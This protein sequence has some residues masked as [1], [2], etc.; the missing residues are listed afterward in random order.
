ML[1][2]N[3]LALRLNSIKPSP[4][5]AITALANSLKEQGKDIVGFGAGEPD[6]DTPVHI[7]EACKLAL[8]NGFTKYTAV[9]GVLSLREAICKKFQT[10]NNL[11]YT[12]NQIIVGTGGKQ[13]L[14]NLFMSV[15]NKGDEVIFSAPYWVSYYDMTLLAEGV[16]KV[17]QTTYEDKFKISPSALENAITEKT[18]I[19]LMNSPSNPTGCIYTFEEL[20]ALAK[21]LEK[22]PHVLIVTDDIY[23]KLIFDNCKFYNLAMISNELAER[24][25]VVNGLSKA[26]AMTG[27]RL[28]YAASKITSIIKAMETMQGQSTSNATSFAQK[29]AEAALLGPLDFLQNMNKAFT[30]RRNYVVQK[31]N[32]YKGISTLV[33]EGAFYVFPSIKNFVEFPKF[34]DYQKSINEISASTAFSKLLLEKYLVAVVPGSAFGYENAFRISYA[35]SMEQIKKGMERIE[36]CVT[37]IIS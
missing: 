21:V 6:F 36:Q 16:P 14:Y 33:P 2:I 25:V 3:F 34:K 4:T 35:T 11:S 32:S 22:H 26:Y 5:L 7:K 10:E 9:Q 31:L 30:E 23:E 20:Q 12:P 27:W 13:V 28:G 1:N 19:F 15:L 24:T 8:D 29:G 37:D 17:I 18:K